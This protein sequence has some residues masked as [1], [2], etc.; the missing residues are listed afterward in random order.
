MNWEPRPRKL[1]SG[2]NSIAVNG[3]RVKVKFSLCLTNQAL[4]HEGVWGSGSIDPRNLG[5]DS[6]GRFSPE[7]TATGRHRVWGWVGPRTGLE[8][9]ERRK[10][11]EIAQIKKWSHFY[12]MQ[13]V[14]AFAAQCCT[15]APSRF[16]KSLFLFLCLYRCKNW[17]S[18]KRSPWNLTQGKLRKFIEIFEFW[19]RSDNNN[20]IFIQQSVCA[21]ARI[22]SVT[23]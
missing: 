1:K 10:Q 11:M 2:K 8:D 17:G 7:D 5:L 22:S 12:N 16:A 6:I 3:H 14:G 23:R 15:N 18:A 13:N 20:E 9:E 4:Q 21:S 19:L